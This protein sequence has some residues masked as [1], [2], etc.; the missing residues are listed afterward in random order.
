MSEY[1]IGLFVGLLIGEGHFGGDGRQPQITLRMHTDHERLFRWL[2]RTFPG[3]RLYGPYHHGGR[4]YFQWMVRGAYLRDTIVP[5]LDRHLHPEI[6]EKAHARY[7][8][9]KA[10]YA[11]QLAPVPTV[12]SAP[13]GP[14]SSAAR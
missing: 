2:E 8:A 4:S 6:D 10:Q 7:Q 5:L 1:D 13:S 9:M 12:P 3:S 11:R 14:S